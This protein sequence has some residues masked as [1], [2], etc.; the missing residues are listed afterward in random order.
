MMKMSIII[1]YAYVL[2]FEVLSLLQLCD[3]FNTC[4]FVICNSIDHLKSTVKI[5][6]VHASRN[7]LWWNAL[8]KGLCGLLLHITNTWSRFTAFQFWTGC[9]YFCY[10]TWTLLR[11]HFILVRVVYSCHLWHLYQMLGLNIS[12]S[13]FLCLGLASSLWWCV[14]VRLISCFKFNSIIFSVWVSKNKL[15]VMVSTKLL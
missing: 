5:L 7:M 8:G 9:L 6:D 1:L 15:L 4:I 13:N 14:G 10:C 3:I 11:I 12:Y 2:I